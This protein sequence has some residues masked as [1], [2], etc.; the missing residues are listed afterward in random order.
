MEQLGIRRLRPRV[1][2][3]GTGSNAANYD[4]SHANPC[5]ALPDPL[6]VRGGRKVTTLAMWWNGRRRPSIR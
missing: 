6:T 4:E 1:S 2:A 3:G 5:P